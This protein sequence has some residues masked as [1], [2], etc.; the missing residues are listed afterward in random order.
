MK[1]KLFM[2]LGMIVLALLL[3]QPAYAGGDLR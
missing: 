2:L 3:I 1:Q